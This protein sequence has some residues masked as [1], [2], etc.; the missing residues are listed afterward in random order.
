MG[1]LRKLVPAV[2]IILVSGLITTVVLHPYGGRFALGIWPV[3]N[4]TPWTYQLESGF[5]P[6]LTVISLLSL[7]GGAWRHINCHTDGCARI[8]RFP[9]A[10]GMFKVCRRHHR[11]I[12]GHHGKLT[13]E[14]LQVAHRLHHK[15]APPG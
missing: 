3:P 12:T 10:G 8:G 1:L 7:I 2:L 13:L 11:D 4:G 5:V 15:Q 14:T 9:V 6:A